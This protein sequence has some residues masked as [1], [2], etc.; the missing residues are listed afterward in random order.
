M[1]KEVQVTNTQTRS[2][3]SDK[4]Y[5]RSNNNGA[6]DCRSAYSILSNQTSKSKTTLSPSDKELMIS[7]KINMLFK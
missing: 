5:V 1:F 2:K 6:K 3:K 4:P 7:K